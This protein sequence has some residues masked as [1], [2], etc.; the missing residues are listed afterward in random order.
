MESASLNEIRKELR[1]L[2]ADAIHEICMRLAKYKKENKEL[3]HYLLF[4]AHNEQAYIE[5]IKD[6]VSDLFKTLPDGHTYYIKK[7]LR[8]ILRHVTRQVKYSG[9]PQTELE[10]RIYFCLKIKEARVPLNTGSVLYNLYNQQ[11]NR[12]DSIL[13]KLPEDLQSDYH[14]ELNSL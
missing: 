13:K 1:H 12:I 9:I 14:A 6:E 11:K 2:D 5:K 8:K 7:T 10:L 4:E 3:L